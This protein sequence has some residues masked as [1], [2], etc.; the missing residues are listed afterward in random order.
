MTTNALHNLIYFGRYLVQ[1]VPKASSAIKKNGKITNRTCDNA[2]YLG[3]RKSG[4][5]AFLILR[6]LIFSQLNKRSNKKNKLSVF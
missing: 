1:F 5:C 3:E 6:F 4:V 2:K